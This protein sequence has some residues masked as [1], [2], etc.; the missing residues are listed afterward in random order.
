MTH[1][2]VGVS[3]AVDV[4]VDKSGGST[5][6]TVSAGSQHSASPEGLVLFTQ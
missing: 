2:L 3:G 1:T 4:A 5:T 6:V